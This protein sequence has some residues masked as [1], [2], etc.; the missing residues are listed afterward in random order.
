LVYVVCSRLP[1]TC[2]EADAAGVRPQQGSGSECPVHAVVHDCAH[3]TCMY[4]RRHAAVDG[5]QVGHR[6]QHLRCFSCVMQ[7]AAAAVLAAGSI[8][9]SA[10]ANELD[11]L[12][13]SAQPLEAP[14]ARRIS[15]ALMCVEEA[16][17]M[18]CP[19]P[20]EPADDHIQLFAHWDQASAAEVRSQLA[21]GSVFRSTFCS[22]SDDQCVVPN[23]RR[24]SRR[25]STSLTTP[26][27]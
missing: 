11:I 8:S 2:A 19:D 6:V 3:H 17:N 14:C 1:A 10:L 5:A 9:G 24:P 16:A 21:S 12:S 18:R 26:V 15:V 20:C 7:A 22:E 23:C 25:R 13:V 4:V 27:C